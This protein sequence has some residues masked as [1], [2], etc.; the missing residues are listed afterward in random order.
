MD[1]TNA[2]PVG[3]GVEIGRFRLK[4]GVS[5]ADM[6]QR[7]AAMVANDLSGQAGWLGQWL[8]VTADGSYI[9]VALAT[10]QA[11]AEKI[12]QSW[13]HLAGPQSFLS[14]IDP[15]DMVFASAV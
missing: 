2:L 8:L 12:C 6:R 3:T 14:L 9:D 4:P 11:S 7:Y 10:D 13:H 1:M 5:D 15:I